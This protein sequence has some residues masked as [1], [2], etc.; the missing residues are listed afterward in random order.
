MLSKKLEG[1]GL[2]LR[3]EH[4]QTIKTTH[5]SIDFIELAPEN[6]MGTGGRR[7]ADLNAISEKYPIICHGLCLSIGSP[8]PLNIKFIKQLKVFLDKYNISIYSEHLS[9]CS[10]ENGYFYDLRPISFTEEMVHYVAKR[11]QQVQGIL[12]RR[13]ALENISYYELPS[14]ELNEQTFI[15]AV[16]NE[17]E[18]DLLLDINNVYVNSIN[19]NYDPL[20]FIKSIP[21]EK[22]RYFHVA[23]HD[24]SD[25]LIIDT[26]GEKINS[27]VI[28]LLKQ[29]YKLFGPLPTLLERDNN[30]PPLSEL[31]IEVENIRAIQNQNKKS[32]YPELIYNNF[33]ATIAQAFPVIRSIVSDKKWRALIE[34]FIKKHKCQT[35]FF[36]EIPQEFLQYLN[37]EYQEDKS[38]PFL[39][40]LAHFEWMELAVELM[41][42]TMKD[43]KFVCCYHYPV[44]KISPD[45]LPT[46]PSKTPY[47][48]LIYR[49]EQ[50]EVKIIEGTK[51][52]FFEVI[53]T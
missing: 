17:A 4:I 26:H 38:L 23:G 28:Q 34:D 47:Y 52:Q 50:N 53:N 14:S 12:E 15:N 13:I 1:I 9:Y 40:E 18:C 35:T 42:D 44:H 20:A 37:N 45:Y 6:W 29:T 32:I 16:L 31:L 25:K 8:V 41:E 30:I 22:I 3:R 46:K 33:S 27:P 2:G 7:A 11:I 5:P 24:S 21:S 43:E 51:E 19:H 36:Y 49:N 39:K 48:F 10:D